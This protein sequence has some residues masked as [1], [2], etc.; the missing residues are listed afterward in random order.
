MGFPVFLSESR[1][2]QVSGFEKEVICDEDNQDGIAPDGGRC[3]GSDRYTEYGYRP[4][5]FSLADRGGVRGFAAVFDSGGR[6]HHRVTCCAPLV[7]WRE[8]IWQS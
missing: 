3:L 8:M 2:A 5:A 7:E 4:S 1:V 6:V